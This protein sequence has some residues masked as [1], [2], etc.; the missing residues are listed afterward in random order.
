MLITHKDCL[1]M[2]GGLWADDKFAQLAM[3]VDVATEIAD[4]LFTVALQQSNESRDIEMRA[5]KK[6]LDKICREDA[7]TSENIGLAHGL[8]SRIEELEEME[9]SSNTDSN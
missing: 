9:C 6:E 5:L 3:D 8:M 2:A 7:Y 1:E 4:L